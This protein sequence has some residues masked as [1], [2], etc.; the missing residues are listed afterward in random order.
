MFL[1]QGPEVLRTHGVGWFFDCM[2]SVMMGSL[3]LVLSFYMNFGVTGRGRS[4]GCYRTALRSL[5]FYGET[6]AL[7]LFISFHNTMGLVRFGF[8]R[9]WFP[10]KA[11]NLSFGFVIFVVFLCFVVV[12]MTTDTHRSV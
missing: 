5:G 1:D 2:P 3:G 7:L 11:V 8:L 4:E 10:H 9:A 6:V 12:E